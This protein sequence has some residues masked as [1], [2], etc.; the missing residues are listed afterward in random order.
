MEN[1]IAYYK[2]CGVKSPDDQINPIFNQLE[3]DI[4]SS[5]LGANSEAYLT[6]KDG[7]K[8]F[9]ETIIGGREKNKSKK[10]KGEKPETE[11]STQQP[12]AYPTSIK[13]Y[14]PLKFKMVKLLFLI[15]KNN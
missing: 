10:I 7:I 3:K 1:I 11:N 12:I 2:I 4:I 15:P 8:T 14:K 9:N 13:L 5:L 6:T